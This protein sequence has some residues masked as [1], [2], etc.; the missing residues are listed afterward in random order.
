MFAAVILVTKGVVVAVVPPVLKAQH[1][2]DG[3]QSPLHLTK[4]GPS[5]TWAHMHTHK[6][7]GE[8][9]HASKE[10]A[11]HSP[12]EASSVHWPGSKQNLP[13]YPSP[14]PVAVTT[15]YLKGFLLSPRSGIKEMLWRE[16][17]RAGTRRD[18]PW[19]LRRPSPKRSQRSAPP[20]HCPTASGAVAWLVPPIAHKIYRKKETKK[21]QRRV[22]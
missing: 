18:V 13:W 20:G 16:T 12:I 1:G 9:R 22:K 2:I 5:R 10:S 11:R 15:P 7:Q 21:Q 19:R 3:V 17:S 6:T 4:R 14:M 8:I